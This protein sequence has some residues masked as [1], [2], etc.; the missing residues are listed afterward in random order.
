[1]S[2]GLSR[3]TELRDDLN[4]A[5]IGEWTQVREQIRGVQAGIDSGEYDAEEPAA[6]DKKTLQVKGSLPPQEKSCSWNDEKVQVAAE[7]PQISEGGFT[8]GGR[9]TALQTLSARLFQEQRLKY[10]SSRAA[11]TQEVPL[12]LLAPA[13]EAAAP[14]EVVSDPNVV[15]SSSSHS[16]APVSRKPEVMVLFLP[17]W[18]DEKQIEKHKRAALKVAQLMV[19]DAGTVRLIQCE[20]PYSEDEKFEPSCY[21]LRPRDRDPDRRRKMLRKQIFAGLVSVLSDVAKYRAVAII[22]S[23][24]GGLIALLCARSL[25]LEVALDWAWMWIW[26]GFGFGSGSV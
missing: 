23:E 12:E 3:E 2:D 9:P 17:P 5:R 24:Q 20:P 13:S 25:V 6:F 26:I 10:Q 11:L 16:A 19:G 15:V 1:M 21:W 18:A 7:Q 14:G 8:L 4:L 22:G